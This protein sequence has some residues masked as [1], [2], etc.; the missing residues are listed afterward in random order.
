[1]QVLELKNSVVK[2]SKMQISS[3]SLLSSEI[4]TLGSSAVRLWCDFG[5][6]LC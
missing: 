4:F 2:K 1:M 5:P 3:I 6:W